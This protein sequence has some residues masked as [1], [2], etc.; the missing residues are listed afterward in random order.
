MSLWKAGNEW[1]E[2]DRLPEARTF[3]Y[4]MAHSIHSIKATV[5]IPQD[6]SALRAHPSALQHQT[7]HDS[8]STFTMFTK[9]G[10]RVWAGKSGSCHGEQAAMSTLRKDS[11]LGMA[12]LT[13]GIEMMPHP[14]C[15]S[16]S[17]DPLS[18][19]L[20]TSAHNSF[21]KA[22]VEG[23]HSAGGMDCTRRGHVTKELPKGHQQ[24]VFLGLCASTAHAGHTGLSP[25]S[26]IL[27]YCSG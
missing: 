18:P 10:Q 15:C 13:V 25:L 22:K 16:K 19:T 7:T 9:Q 14:S 2:M 17:S 5:D 4:S 20:H 23:W 24:P 21:P 1:A 11:K 8:C 12:F 3:S 27:S 6:K 26:L